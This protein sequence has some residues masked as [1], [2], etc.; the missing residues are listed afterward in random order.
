MQLWGS[1]ALHLC[2]IAVNP[3]ALVTEAIGQRSMPL[4]ILGE[5]VDHGIR[6]ANVRP[7]HRTSLSLRW[8][9]RPWASHD[10]CASIGADS[11]R[12]V[13]PRFMWGRLYEARWRLGRPPVW[14]N[15]ILEGI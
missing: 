7:R 4:R 2:E 8:R 9:P 14:V 13:H 6:D 5:E 1:R 12:V 10:R 3:A 11:S 15:L